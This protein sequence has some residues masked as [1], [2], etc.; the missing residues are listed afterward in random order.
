MGVALTE[1][2]L[3]PFD[4]TR[5]EVALA[6]ELDVMV[7]AH[8]GTVTSAQRPP[9]VE[10]LHAA[11]LLDHRQV[12]VH[13]NACSEPRAGPA[14]RRRG[15]GVA[16]AGDRA[17]DG[18]GL[19]DL[20]ARAGARAR[21]R[22][23]AATSSPTTAATCSRRCASG[24][25]RSARGPTRRALDDLE[26]P[27]ELTLGVRDV[28]R[29]ATLGGAEALGLDSVCGSIEP[30]KAADLIVLRT[31][32][33]HLAPLNDPV[34]TVV[35]HAGP[36]D[37]DTVLVGG[38][39]VKEGGALTGGRAR[40]GARA[41]RG[42]A[43]P[44]RRRARAARRPA[45]AGAR[46][47]VRGH[48][49]GDGAEPRER[50]LGAGVMK[51]VDLSAPIE[52]SPAELLEPLRTEIEFSDH[53]A[54]AAMAEQLLRRDAAT[55]CGTARP[56]RRRTSAGSAPTTRPTSTRRGTTTR[57]SAASA[58]RRSTSCRSSGSWRRAS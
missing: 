29:F 15:V 41:G 11:G 6:R 8:I 13:C 2:G 28:L 47:L 33:L 7:T 42:L 30:G 3:V 34:A 16:D 55:C 26:M 48:D 22:A 18:H 24:C 50:G 51:I 46:G 39:V 12:H 40:G 27:Q 14:G 58:R 23:S 43:R 25:R 1:L 54:G 53:A 38:Q 49:A 32:R 37:V 52:N 45:A 44:H 21:R 19:P 56:G 5:A 9:E 4:V 17:A 20:R 31:D 10:L 35:L 36:A 57:T